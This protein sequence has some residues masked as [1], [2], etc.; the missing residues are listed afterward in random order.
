VDAVVLDIG[1]V[2]TRCGFAGEARPRAVVPHGRPASL[3]RPP[4]AAALHDVVGAH[5]FGPWWSLDGVGDADAAALEAVVTHHL[6][7][8]YTQYLLIDPS[9]RPVVLVEPALMPVP[10]KTMLVRVLLTVFRVPA[11]TPVPAALMGLLTTGRPE[12]L[13][14]DCGYLEA[15]IVPI[16]D[17]RALMAHTVS[18]PCAGATVTRQLQREVMRSG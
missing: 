9:Q 11:V 16:V 10:V 3:V 17:H 7:A 4:A 12:G 6:A 13:V 15:T 14:V 2:M 5:A 18:V 8:I 1:S